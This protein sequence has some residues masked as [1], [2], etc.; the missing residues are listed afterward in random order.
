MLAGEMR[1]APQ[2][3]LPAIMFAQH[4][5]DARGKP[6][7]EAWQRIATL[8][9]REKG[10]AILGAVRGI[11]MG[12]AYGI[13]AGSLLGRLRVRRYRVDA[14]SSLP[15]ELAMLVSLFIFS[16]GRRVP[17]AG[18]EP[19]APAGRAPMSAGR[20][21]TPARDFPRGPVSSARAAVNIEIKG[22]R[23]ARQIGKE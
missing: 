21:P 23:P 20:F 12:N 7:Q 13:P 4:Y 18:R 3:E 2:E 10:M 6:S 16:A 1:G 14:R 15:Y 11:M 8:Y 22:N 5:A 19:D 9:G 17:G